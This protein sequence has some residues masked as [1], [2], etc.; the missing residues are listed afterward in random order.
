MVKILSEPYPI[1]DDDPNVTAATTFTASVWQDCWKYRVPEKTQIVLQATDSISAYLADSGD[2]EITDPDFRF[3]I[4]VRDPSE[5]H[6]ER[7]F[8]PSNYLP[9]KEMQDTDK[10]A[11]LNLEHPVK[12]PAKWWIVIMDWD[13]TGHDA[14]NIVANGAGNCYFILRTTKVRETL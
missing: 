14:A 7:V 4:E 6:R 10:F 12:V 9:I 2:A 13:A 11:Y 3:K 5:Q 1:T 8:G